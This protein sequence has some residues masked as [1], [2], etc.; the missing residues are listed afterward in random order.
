MCCLL[1]FFGYVAP[2]LTIFIVWFASG[3]FGRAYETT[4]WPLLG[5]FFM[6]YTML[7]YAICMNEG[8]G[9]AGFWV[10]LFAIGLL[11]DFG[12]IGGS[13]RARGKRAE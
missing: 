5:F 9:I 3:Y 12:V 11:L 8:G 13:A 4:L 1:A 2:R 7:A 10:A 6:P